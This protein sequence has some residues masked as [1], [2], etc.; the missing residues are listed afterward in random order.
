MQVYFT[1]HGVQLGSE[2]DH[3]GFNLMSLFI[4]L[5][6]LGMFI[7]STFIENKSETSTNSVKLPK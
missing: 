1:A 6:Y 7:Y 2:T 4:M 3:S 5:I